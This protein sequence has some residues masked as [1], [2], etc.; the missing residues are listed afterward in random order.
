MGHARAGDVAGKAGVEE[1][2]AHRRPVDGALADLAEKK[3]PASHIQPEVFYMQLDDPAGAGAD[4]VLGMAEHHVADVQIGAR[5]RRLQFVDVAGV[6]ERAQQETV[7]DV[8][9]PE[10]D[11]HFFS[12]GQQL[13][14]DHRLRS[15][16]RVLIRRLGIDH[17]RDQQQRVGAPEPG[18]GQGLAD[19][20]DAFFYLVRV[21]AR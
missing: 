21:F 11:A 18:I 16:I 3:A 10:H 5:P 4:P 7:P 17:R 15:P 19:G 2:G 14:P 8:L 20:L 6:F 12:Q 13:P 1:R 9:D